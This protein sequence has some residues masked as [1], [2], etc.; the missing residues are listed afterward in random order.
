MIATLIATLIMGLYLGWYIKKY[1]IPESISQ[2]VF[3]LP[4]EVCFTLVMYSVGFL[5]IAQMIDHCSENT[6]FL[7]FLSIAGVLFV[8]AAPLGK[9]CNEKVHIAGAL[10]FG[11]CS[12]I[13]IALNA[14]LLLL[15]WVPCVFWLLKSAGRHYKFWLEMACIIDLLVFCL[16]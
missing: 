9:D 4:H 12:Q 5:N 3:K 11:I 8:G 6:K 15:G 2:T 14:P 16:L 10:F 1:G 7:A 13:M